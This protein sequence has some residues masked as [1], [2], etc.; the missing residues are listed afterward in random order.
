M[1]LLREQMAREDLKERTREN[2]ARLAKVFSRFR[3]T[4]QGSVVFE[5]RCDFGLTFIEEPFMSYGSMVDEDELADKL[6]MD[7]GANDQTPLP[8]CSGSVLEW[9]VDERGFY[10]GAWVGARVYFPKEI[11]FVIDPV[12]EA[13]VAYSSIPPN[14]PEVPVTLDVEVVHM[15]SFEAVALKDVPLAVE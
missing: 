10:I 14:L 5:R 6:D 4:G 13:Q 12:T 1:D 8:M 11:T 3:T 7:S 2:S 9:D 15:F